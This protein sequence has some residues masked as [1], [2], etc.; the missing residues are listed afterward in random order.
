[1]REKICQ[2][3]TRP[4]F[5]LVAFRSANNS[6]PL[7][8]SFHSFSISRTRRRGWRKWSPLAWSAEIFLSLHILSLRI[9]LVCLRLL[10]TKFWVLLLSHCHPSQILFQSLDLAVLAVYSYSAV[11]VLLEF[12][13][14]L[15]VR[16]T[17]DAFPI[18]SRGYC[19][20]GA[21]ETIQSSIK[22]LEPS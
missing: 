5:D 21:K 22:S 15:S 20:S 13:P 14:S 11:S 16:T 7:L 4:K 8:I 18:R 19:Q 12:L 1:M 9:L 6:P 10:H 17:E 2:S 3:P